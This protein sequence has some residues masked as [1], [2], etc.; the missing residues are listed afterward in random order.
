MS[1]LKLFRIKSEDVEELPS[2]SVAL[3]KSLQ[4]LIEKNLFYLK[5]NPDSIDQEKDFHRD[6]R[7]IGHFGTGN[8]EETIGS[9]EAF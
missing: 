7:K 2:Q 3:E 6:V 5:V 9:P 8:L 4:N 1:D